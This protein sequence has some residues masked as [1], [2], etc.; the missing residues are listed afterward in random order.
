MTEKTGSR[1][2][3][4]RMGCPL[5]GGL[6]EVTPRNGVRSSVILG[7]RMWTLVAREELRVEPLV[8]HVERSQQ[9]WPRGSVWECFL[10]ASLGKC[11]RA[12]P[13]GEE[14]QRTTRDALHGRPL[15]AGLGPEGP[16][17]IRQRRSACLCPDCCPPRPNN[18]GQAA[19]TEP[20]MN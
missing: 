4:A 12:R 2:Q 3:A 14:T 1:T 13:F 17:R 9:R 10:D 5:S 6:G 19:E 7:D 8:L 15:S 20:W 18:Y 11:F 16:H